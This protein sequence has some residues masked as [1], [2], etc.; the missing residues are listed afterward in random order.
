MNATRDD[1]LKI[2]YKCLAEL[3]E[4][5]P[6]AAHLKPA[7]ETAL[8]GDSGTLDSLGMVNL[9]TSIEENLANHY[10]VL[11]SLPSSDLSSGQDPWR[12]VGVLANF[13]VDVVNRR[14]S[15]AR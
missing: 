8:L 7:E 15:S 6:P 3:N 4:Q 9:V 2:L 1:I 10:G 5:L 12:N 11:I 14:L 13:L